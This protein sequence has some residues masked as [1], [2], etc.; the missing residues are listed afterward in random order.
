MTDQRPVDQTPDRLRPMLIGAGV[1]AGAFIALF[2]LYTIQKIGIDVPVWE[3]WD[4]L[5]VIGESY[6]GGPWLR[7]IFR[8]L[9]GHMVAVPMLLFIGFSRLNGWN[10]MFEMYWGWAAVLATCVVLTRWVRAMRLPLPLKVLFFVCMALL[11]FGLRASEL[12]LNGLNSGVFLSYFLIVLTIELARE[13]QTSWLRSIAAAVTGLL[14]TWSWGAGILVWPVGGLLLL[15]HTRDR[16]G[17]IAVW[18][19][20]GLVALSPFVLFRVN[21]IATA[22]PH[23]VARMP[24]WFLNMVSAPYSVKAR[25]VPA[26]LLLPLMIATVGVL[27]SRAYR[28]RALVPELLPWAALLAHGLLTILLV[29]YMRTVSSDFFPAQPRYAFVAAFFSVGV[30]GLFLLAVRELMEKAS[31]RLR[32]AAWGAAAAVLLIVGGRSAYMSHEVYTLLTGWQPMRSALDAFM[33]RA[34]Q[35]ATEGQF[36]HI[37]QQRGDLIR[38]GLATLR[39]WHLGPYR[40]AAAAV[41]PLP[42]EEWIGKGLQANDVELGVNQ[43]V[44]RGNGDLEVYGWAV[45]RQGVRPAEFVVASAEGKILEQ[46]LTDIMSY[47][48]APGPDPTALHGW[49]LMIPAH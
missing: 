13:P 18:C 9:F 21:D 6:E 20:L 42:L 31:P 33:R 5:P 34:P 30:L 28:S 25:I 17:K 23:D 12:T 14:A 3:H 41:P 2:V 32:Q 38:G 11:V 46:A 37:V 15:L 19:A 49:R 40:T 47:P 27:G 36:L 16:R 22:A 29:L 48:P 1:A 24:R 39:R 45:D 35:Y 8:P 7:S 44:L 43:S 4:F 26:A 10:L